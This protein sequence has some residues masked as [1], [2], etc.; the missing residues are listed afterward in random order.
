MQ[1]SDI[2]RL[3]LPKS[4]P[5]SIRAVNQYGRKAAVLT[6]DGEVFMINPSTFQANELIG[7]SEKEYVIQL[8]S[9]YLHFAAL[10]NTG[11]VFQWGAMAKKE[12]K[13]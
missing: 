9:N 12:I 3:V 5:K 4:L 13:R 7:R 10:T 8:E 2:T 1:E 11:K 6:E